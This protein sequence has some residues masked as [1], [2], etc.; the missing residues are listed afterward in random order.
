MSDRPLAQYYA[1]IAEAVKASDFDA[2]P[3]LLVIMASDGYAHEAETLRREIQ[4]AL[5]VAKE[6]GD[7]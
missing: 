3:G 4:V 5:D 1:A 6:L 7:D 2:V